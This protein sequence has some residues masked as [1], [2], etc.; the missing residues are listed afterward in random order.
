MT[1]D[2]RL[3]QTQ[4]TRLNL[5]DL[6]G[7]LLISEMAQISNSFQMDISTLAPGVYVLNL[8]NEL[9]NASRRVVLY[10]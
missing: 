10:K 8:S 3:L 2:S 5:V 7:K 4:G 1:I 6:K 9:G